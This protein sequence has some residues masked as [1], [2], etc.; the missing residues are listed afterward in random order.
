M[1]NR[2]SAIGGIDVGAVQTRFTGKPRPR[3]APGGT[4][5]GSAIRMQ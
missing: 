2:T 3:L 1:M 5:A 4:A